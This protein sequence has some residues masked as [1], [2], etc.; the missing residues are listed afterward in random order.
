[1]TGPGVTRTLSEISS[2]CQKAARGTGCHWGL[3]EEAGTAARVLES[4]GLSGSDC[5]AAILSSDRA[6]P[7]SGATSGPACGIEAAARLSDRIQEVCSDD[8][9]ELGEIIGPMLLAAPLV[10]AA[11][12]TGASYILTIDGH[13]LRICRDG[14]ASNIRDL[15][16]HRPAKFVS[17]AR[18]E[19]PEHA[20]P[21]TPASREIS[22]K[23]WKTLETLAAKTLVPETEQSRSSGAGPDA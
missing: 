9:M 2:T 8:T 10:L 13:E 19:P 11:C 12:R 21:A 18:S 23:T 5:V 15:E 22:A 14:V 7:C 4:V 16:M 1:M 6:C 20:V 3:A 17:V